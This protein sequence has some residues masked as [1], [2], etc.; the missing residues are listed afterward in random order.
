MLLFAT[1]GKVVGKASSLQDR[2]LNQKDLYAIYDWSV[3]NQLPLCQ[4]KSQCLYM[5]HKNGRHA[6]ML[7][8]A[9]IL[10]V[11]ECTD[12]GIIRTSDFSYATHIKS[13]MRKASCLSGML[14]RAFSS[15]NASFIIKLFIAYV[16]PIIAST[17]WN[18]SS[19]GLN[20]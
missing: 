8:G 17:V 12:L 1:D 9:P 6:Y 15:R 10:A 20:R 5:G 3:I 4:P 19:I 18:P 2:E 7:G 11:E 13:V 16:R 14:F